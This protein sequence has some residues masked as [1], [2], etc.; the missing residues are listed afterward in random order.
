MEFLHKC[1]ENGNKSGLIDNK[2]E[3]RSTCG[4]GSSSERDLSSM[5]PI[6]GDLC[7]SVKTA[8]AQEMEE[9][10]WAGLISLA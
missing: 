10:R 7:Q 6:E 3:R 1:C 9:Y 2:M 8:T 4:P 5:K